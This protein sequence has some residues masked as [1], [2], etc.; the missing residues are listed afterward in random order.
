VLKGHPFP[1]IENFIWIEPLLRGHLSYKA[2]F[3]LF[4][5]S[6]VSTGLTLDDPLQSCH[7]FMDLKSKEQF[8]FMGIL[9]DLY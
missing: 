9:I 4:L 2:T 6:P 3:V 5:R 7:F 1:V 8:L